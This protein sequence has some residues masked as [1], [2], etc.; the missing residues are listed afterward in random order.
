MQKQRNRA[1][2]EELKNIAHEM[3][4]VYDAINIIQE[5]EW[6]INKPVYELVDTC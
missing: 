6:A 4:D 1:Y 5:T 3:P 2:L